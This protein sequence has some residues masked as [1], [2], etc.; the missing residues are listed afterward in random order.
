MYKILTKIL[1]ILST[2][3]LVYLLWIMCKTKKC[4]THQNL[5]WIKCKWIKW[6]TYFGLV[7]LL[8][9][10]CKTMK[11]AMHC[12]THFG[13]PNFCIKIETLR[14]DQLV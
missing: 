13:I 2:L 5:L 8:W 3:V 11:L 14:N 10:M 9:V 4:F 1:T 7:Y 6:I 12:F